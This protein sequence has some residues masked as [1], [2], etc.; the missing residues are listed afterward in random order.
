MGHLW[1]IFLEGI[2]RLFVDLVLRGGLGAFWEGFGVDFGIDFGRILELF[3]NIVLHDL[4][5]CFLISG[6]PTHACSLGN[7]KAFS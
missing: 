7:L 3:W 4:Y 1:G 5:V 2:S 6:P